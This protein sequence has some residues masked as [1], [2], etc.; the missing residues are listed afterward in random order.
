MAEKI[1]YDQ[2]FD[3]SKVPQNTET[4]IAIKR[5]FEWF[6]DATLNIPS[7]DA[8]TGER[9]ET[10]TGQVI[11][12]DILTKRT[13]G[14]ESFRKLSEEIEKSRPDLKE[15]IAKVAP[16]ITVRCPVI[17][18][19]KDADFTK[20]QNTANTSTI[21]S[22]QNFPAAVSINDQYVKR[23]YYKGVDGKDHKVA[24][25]G[26]LGNELFHVLTASTDENLSIQM[27]SAV[28]EALGGVQ[29]SEEVGEGVK[30]SKTPTGVSSLL[31][32]KAKI[33]AKKEEK[34][35]DVP[36]GTN[37]SPPRII[38]PQEQKEKSS[39]SRP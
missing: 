18:F 1:T 14:V 37:V 19:D 30:I 34:T 17:L 8:N 32:D 22:F 27:E 2:V 38:Q 36:D 13:N 24:V 4:G 28:L 20:V 33:E 31:A 26:I 12:R 3:L 5:F 35:R 21:P 7:I 23:G 10:T 11:L 15:H 29:R 39:P 16:Y 6:Q 9:K 25:E